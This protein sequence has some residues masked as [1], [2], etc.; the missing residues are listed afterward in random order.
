MQGTLDLSSHRLDAWITSFATK[1]LAA[2]RARQRRRAAGGGYGWVENL[3][4]RRPRRRRRHAAAGRSRRRS[5]TSPNDSGFI[6]APSLTHAAAAALLRNAHLGATGVP[7]ADSPF[8]IELS[9]R[10]VREAARL[11]DGMRQG[12]PLARCSA[13]ASSAACTTSAL[14]RF[15]APL[16]NLAPLV[17]AAARGDHAARREDRRQQRRRRTRVVREMARRASRRRRTRCSRRA[18]TPAS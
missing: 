3:R 9:S 11:I 16:R 18:P 14:D 17:G 7:S 5:S 12:Q 15:I 6:H 1:R 2:M 8:A 13:I 4:P 10:R